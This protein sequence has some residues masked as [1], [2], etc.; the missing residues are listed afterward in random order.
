M[1]DVKDLLKRIDAA[2]AA[3]GSPLAADEISAHEAEFGAPY[4]SEL[5]R[6]DAAIPEPASMATLGLGAIALLARRR[7]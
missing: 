3:N 2:F 6:L 5:A 4:V 7:K 1:P